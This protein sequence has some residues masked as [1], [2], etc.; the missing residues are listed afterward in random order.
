MPSSHEGMGKLE[1]TG[2]SGSE[3]FGR[4]PQC[5][6]IVK[7][8]TCLSEGFGTGLMCCGEVVTA[9]GSGP[10][11]IRKRISVLRS[12]QGELPGSLNE[13]WRKPTVC[14][15]EPGDAWKGKKG[16]MESNG[17]QPLMITQ[18]SAVG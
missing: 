1:E 18:R 17:F 2:V 10:R 11:G 8:P 16:R 12:P 4:N 3:A 9:V 13:D 15:L 5:W 14:G 6:Y 7:G